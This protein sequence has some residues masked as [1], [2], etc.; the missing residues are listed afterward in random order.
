MCKW[1]SCR[2]LGWVAIEGERERGRREGREGRG[3]VVVELGENA[4]FVVF[5]GSVF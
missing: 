5:S 4:S 2:L 3:G 1:G